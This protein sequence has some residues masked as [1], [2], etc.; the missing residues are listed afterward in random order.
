MSS[1][2]TFPILLRLLLLLLLLVDVVNTLNKSTKELCLSKMVSSP[3]FVCVFESSLI[4]TKAKKRERARQRE[5]FERTMTTRAVRRRATFGRRGM[6][7]SSST[8]RCIAATVVVVC[9]VATMT[10][11]AA[12]FQTTSPSSSRRLLLKDGVVGGGVGDLHLGF[13]HSGET[14]PVAQTK[15]S[16]GLTV[17]H[18]RKIAGKNDAII[19]T[20]AN[21]HY[22]DFARNWINHVQNRLGLT[23]FIVG[24][25]DEKMYE[26]LK[27]EFRG[28]V[29]T[30][31]MGSQGIAKDAV[32]NDFGWGTRNFHQMGRDKIRLIRDFTRSGVNVLVSDIDVVWLRNPLPFFKRYPKADVLVSSDQLRSETMIESA[33]QKKFIVDGEGL[34]F[35]I[36]HAASNIGIMWFLASRGNQELTTEW[37][38]RI[39]KDDNLWDQSAFNDLK[40]LNGGC[41]TQV[42]GSGVQEAYGDENNKM[43]VKMGALPVSLFANGHTY[44]VQ[45]LHERERKNAY[46]VHATFQYGGTPGKRNRMREANAWMGDDEE[47]F[48]GKFMS[49]TPRVERDFFRNNAESGGFR[50]SDNSNSTGG[51]SDSFESSGDEK[52]KDDMKKVRGG[53]DIFV[54]RGWPEKDSAFPSIP[55]KE[56]KVLTENERLVNFQLAQINEALAIAK[57][58]DRILIMPPILCGIDRVWFPHYGRFPGSHLQLPFICPQDHVINV[59][60]WRNGKF[61]ERSFL[62]HPQMPQGA[63][64]PDSS[65]RV[66]V[67]G[68]KTNEAFEKSRTIPMEITPSTRHNL[69]SNTKISLRRCFEHHDAY[70]N[71][72]DDDDDDIVERCD[73]SQNLAIQNANTVVSLE[74]PAENLEALEQM[75]GSEVNS[76]KF[77]HFDTIL[78]ATIESVAKPESNAVPDYWCCHMKGS[79]RYKPEGVK[80]ELFIKS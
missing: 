53:F 6:S 5:P 44:Y 2:E 32:K 17:E 72:N 50:S 52:D 26:S 9:V 37:V 67:N 65:A 45:R 73:P 14:K 42:D 75:L 28:G 8:T 54:E 15:L 24:A 7:S 61:R 80:E 74:K 40:S 23:N 51:S 56:E 36:C 30:W 12:A 70:N 46:A 55:T 59:E 78:G 71:N 41:Q 34:E 19:V 16:T 10:S 39:E 49:F 62:M 22:L 27:E 77:L 29:H 63:V 66:V 68:R 4:E 47:Y 21:H 3:F 18:I 25:M 38:E 1:I 33:K 79:V 13:S 11:A 64:S 58:L 48:R 43:R 20:W 57:H 76:K 69:D 60:Q 31:L 35:H